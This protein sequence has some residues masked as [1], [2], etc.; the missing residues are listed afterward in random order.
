MLELLLTAALDVF[1]V[2]LLKREVER[3]TEVELAGVTK[4]RPAGDMDW[5]RWSGRMPVVDSV[6][7]SAMPVSDDLAVGMVQREHPHPL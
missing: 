4:D 7:R 3:E 6:I 5:Q 1:V 2:A